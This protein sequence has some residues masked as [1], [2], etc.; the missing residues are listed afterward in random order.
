MIFYF[1]WKIEEIAWGLEV[2]LEIIQIQKTTLQLTQLVK[3]RGVRLHSDN[4]F[5]STGEETGQPEAQSIGMVVL[6]LETVKSFDHNDDISIIHNLLIDLL[7]TGLQPVVEVL[8]QLFIRKFHLM[9]DFQNFLHKKV[10]L[11]CWQIL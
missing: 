7:F 2:N 4:E 11:S 5:D 6:L 10:T 8:S 3:S 1:C 9:V